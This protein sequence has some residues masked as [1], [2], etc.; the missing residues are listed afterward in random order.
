[1]SA[2]GDRGVRGMRVRKISPR[3]IITAF[4]IILVISFYF[5]IKNMSESELHVAEIVAI[6]ELWLQSTA[7]DAKRKSMILNPGD[8]SRLTFQ[9]KLL[10]TVGN[11]GAVNITYDGKPY[12]A[13]NKGRPFPQHFTFQP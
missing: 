2:G 10:L 1:M 7:D 11:A 8:H 13:G 6:N 5:L 12:H 9:K 3:L 4:I